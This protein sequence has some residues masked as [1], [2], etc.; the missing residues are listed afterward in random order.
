[1][2]E[3]L[4]ESELAAILTRASTEL[5]SGKPLSLGVVTLLT[6][7]IV[8]LVAE[9]RTMRLQ[10]AARGAEVRGAQNARESV[11]HAAK[12]EIDRLNQQLAARDAQIARYREIVEN[13]AAVAT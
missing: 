8:L 2:S 7:D 3:H 6:R 5:R 13:G 9:F 10:L 4:P 1:M 12:A 11:F